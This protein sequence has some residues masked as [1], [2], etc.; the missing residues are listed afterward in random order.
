MESS[1]KIK[2]HAWTPGADLVKKSQDW[3]L[4]F[5]ILAFFFCFTQASIWWGKSEEREHM[6]W[7]RFNQAAKMNIMKVEVWGKTPFLF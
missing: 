3:N 5:L 2:W 7:S 6:K 4:E 1:P